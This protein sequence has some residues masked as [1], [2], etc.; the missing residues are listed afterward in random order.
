MKK[1]VVDPNPDVDLKKLQTLSAE[2]SDREYQQNLDLRKT[3]EIEEWEKIAE[4]VREIDSLI[5]DIFSSGI[6]RSQISHLQA[7]IDD[8]GHMRYSL[9]ERF[10]EEYP[11]V[12]D[13]EVFY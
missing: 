1:L 9:E 13:T 6:P 7:I 8:L 3:L 10:F 12:A 2:I 5:T 4:K 11:E